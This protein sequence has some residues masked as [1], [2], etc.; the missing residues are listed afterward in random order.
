MKMK[1][2]L[3]FDQML[4]I[5]LIQ[6]FMVINLRDLIESTTEKEVMLTLKKRVFSQGIGDYIKI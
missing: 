2:N 5:Q 3:I 6:T 1:L 4:R